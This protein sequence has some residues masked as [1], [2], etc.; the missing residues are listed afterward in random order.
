VGLYETDNSGGDIFYANNVTDC[1][2]GAK[3]VGW[4]SNGT[5]L[6]CNNF[7]NN[8]QQVNTDANE[9]D[10]DNFTRQL[11]HGGSFDNQ[12]IGN[13]WSDYNGTDADGDGVGDAPYV[14][15][16]NRADHYPLM[17]AFN[18]SSVTIQIPEWAN[19]T[20][21][22]PIST[23]SFPPSPTPFPTPVIP[24]TTPL[25]ALVALVVVTCTVATAIRKK[26]FRSIQ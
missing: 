24:E 18:I 21:P 12:T 6:Y 8:T 13:F 3:I 11:Y 22:N 7:V 26:A 1:S 17:S 9:T 19:I 10:W 16:A 23:P 14:I 5:V 20:V 15:D 2:C 25:A 4:H